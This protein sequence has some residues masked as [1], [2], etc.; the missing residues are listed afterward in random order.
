MTSPIDHVA[1][2]E[3]LLCT[4]TPVDAREVASLEQA[5][6]VLPSL[7]QPFSEDAQDTHV[8]ASGFVVGPRG[9]LL[10]HHLKLGIWVQPGGHI[11]EGEWPHGAA[12]REVLE[13]TGL[14][15]VDPPGGPTVVRIDVHPGPRGHT[16]LDLGFLFVGGDDDPAPPP[17][18]SQA[19]RW[20]TIDEALALAEPG[21]RG[22]LGTLEAMAGRHGVTVGRGARKG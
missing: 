15:V 16:H 17:H 10:H 22:F 6:A 20:C 19:V 2:V 12:Q 9:V 3:A 13:E 7:A 5:R 18:E 14:E 21:L 1:H 11:D 4:L 8:T